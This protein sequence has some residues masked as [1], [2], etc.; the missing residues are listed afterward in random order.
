MSCVDEHIFPGCNA[1][2]AECSGDVESRNIS[3]SH[4]DK[5]YCQTHHDAHL[6]ML[7]LYL[8]EDP[9]NP[10]MAF[11]LV[12]DVMAM[13]PAELHQAWLDAQE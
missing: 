13:T 3:F 8:T 9:A 6:E 7:Y 2:S 12:Q 5:I 4:G 1:L 10:P 11:Y